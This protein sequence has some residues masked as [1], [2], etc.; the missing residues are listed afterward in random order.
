MAGEVVGVNSM[1]ARNGSIGFAIPVNLV[2]VLVPQLAEKGKVDWGWLGVS[3]AEVPEDEARYGSRR[4]EAYSCAI[5]AGQ[6]AEGRRLRQRRDHGRGRR[7]VEGPRDLQRIISR[8]PI[9]RP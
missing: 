8:T 4:R 7:A 1:A 5:M 9:G 3:I 6:P 2:K